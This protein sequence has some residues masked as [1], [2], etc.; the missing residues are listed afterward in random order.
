GEDLGHA[1]RLV[2]RQRLGD[3]RE[4]PLVDDRQLALPAATDY[5]HH[6][7]AELEALRR[8]PAAYD[9][10]GELQAG[11]VL[12]RAGRRRIVAGD[13]VDVG[14]VEPGGPRAHEHLAVPRLRIRVIA[15]DDL[16]V[17]DGDGAHGVAPY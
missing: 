15:D 12:R 4:H 17:D 2:E 9:L 6:P 7:V 13:L 10:P 1:A 11:D 16:A 3:R 8:R 14:A 5:P